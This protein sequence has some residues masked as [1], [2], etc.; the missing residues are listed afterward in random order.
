MGCRAR[1]V[2]ADLLR[3]PLDRGPT[4]DFT[5]LRQP[6]D[7][8]DVGGDVTELLEIAAGHDE[9]TVGMRVVIRLELTEP[10]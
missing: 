9:A 2:D 5:F 8:G 3:V 7:L 10:D 6:C 4:D 1:D